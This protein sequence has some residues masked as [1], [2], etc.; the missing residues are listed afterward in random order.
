MPPELVT[1]R[2]EW[3][4]GE[5][6]ALATTGDGG[7]WLFFTTLADPSVDDVSVSATRW[8]PATAAWTTPAEILR[9][10]QIRPLSGTTL[11]ATT[12]PVT[13]RVAVVW[14]RQDANG[15]SRGAELAWTDDKGGNWDRRSFDRT[16]SMPQ[17]ALHGG[18]MWL[19]FRDPVGLTVASSA[20]PT[21]DES[22][23]YAA[24][25]LL[26]GRRPAAL[27]ALLRLT[28]VDGAVSTNS[29]S[30]GGSES[31]GV[32]SG[33]GGEPRQSDLVSENGE[34]TDA[35][36]RTTAITALASMRPVVTFVTAS[37]ERPGYWLTTWSGASPAGT[38]PVEA[39]TDLTQAEAALSSV[40]VGGS[41]GTRTRAVV[42]GDGR[43]CAVA[44][45]S[46]SA[47]GTV[48][49]DRCPDLTLP[50]AAPGT[51]GSTTTSVPALV[52]TT[53]PPTTSAGG[54]TTATTETPVRQVTV[55]PTSSLIPFVAGGAG[56]GANVGDDPAANS[57]PEL[58]LAV[59]R[60]S[61][62]PPFSP[63]PSSTTSTV[64]SAG[65]AQVR[66]GIYVW[67]GRLSDAP[68]GTIIAGL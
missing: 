42:G 53:T 9:G 1:Q 28:P 63:V 26:E 29:N 58:L 51:P 67:R 36:K 31:G 10:T 27:P 60:F 64:A 39:S 2:R 13:G 16:A 22:W 11:R 7:A 15:A 33:A 46:Q 41:A 44:L 57:E 24:V 43:P 3:W 55:G 5:Q 17:L 8:N 32:P 62:A 40:G 65:G 23:T 68:E 56:G 6:L 30:A 18:A 21:D 59:V 35:A 50:G 12:D 48:N 20:I 14:E 54:P 49:A 52:A 4:I 25:P 19:A 61:V 66:P 37:T 34:P 38:A 45:A 47:D